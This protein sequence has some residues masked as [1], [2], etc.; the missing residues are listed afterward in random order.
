MVSKKIEKK[1]EEQEGDEP[2]K[3]EP[4]E[5]VEPAEPEPSE[6]EPVKEDSGKKVDYVGMARNNPWIVSTVVLGIVL[7]VVL[8]MGGGGSGMTGNV[9]SETDAGQNLIDFIESRGDG[10]S[11]S[12]VSVEKEDSLYKVVVDI[13]GQQT[14]VYVT[15]DGKY[16]I[17]QPIPLTAQAAPSGDSASGQTPQP[18]NVPK[19]DKPVV[20]AFVMAYCPY[21]TQIEKG[22][23]PVVKL[24]GDKIDFEFKFV[25]YAMHPAQGEV[26]EQTREYCIQKEQ[27]DK[28]LDYL[29]CFLGE[30]DSEGCL[31]S[32]GIDTA[33]LDACYE[34]TDAEFDITKNLEDKESWSG[35]R[36]PMFLIH[37]EENE[38]Y[39]VRGSPTLVIN[40]VTAS[41]GRDSASLLGAICNAFNEEPSECDTVFEGGTPSPGFGWGETDSANLAQCG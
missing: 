25:N 15:L 19:S 27:N 23:I 11:A 41:A 37:A 18:A 40:G 4:T 38:K 26:E 34:A 10:T 9:I 6:P 21:G 35:G 36:F 1:M 29:A 14:P 22:L 30:G 20:E 3:S 24:L 12:I 17:A 32:T 33:K 8:V 13:D 7:I 5:P 16:A 28:F 31:A 2:D 39:G